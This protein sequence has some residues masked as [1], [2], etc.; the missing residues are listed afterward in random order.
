MHL[1]ITKI[2]NH[3]SVPNPSGFTI[4]YILNWELDSRSLT[5]RESNSLGAFVLSI[6]G[7]WID[8]NSFIFSFVSTPKDVWIV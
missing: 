7:Y 4:Q 2:N 3:G 6:G 1:N 8:V 5:R